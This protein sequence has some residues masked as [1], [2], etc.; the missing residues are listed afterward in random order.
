MF[1]SMNLILCL[2]VPFT[3]VLDLV[4]SKKVYLEK[5][6]AYVPKTDLVS[7]ILSVYRTHLSHALAVSAK[8]IT[9]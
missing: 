5:G 7:I 6:F 9:P 8:E 3:E 1:T 4:R 2:Q